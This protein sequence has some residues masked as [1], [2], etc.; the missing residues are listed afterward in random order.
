MPLIDTEFM[1]PAATQCFGIFSQCTCANTS[2]LDDVTCDCTHEQEVKMAG[3]KK[4]PLV[5][6][7]SVKN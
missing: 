7:V 3:S 4:P 6:Y 1:H 5:T 2:A